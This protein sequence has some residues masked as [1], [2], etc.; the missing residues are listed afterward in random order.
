MVV[1]PSGL[2]QSMIG[3]SLKHL[4]EFNA[5]ALTDIGPVAATAK[6]ASGVKARSRQDGK[7]MTRRPFRQ[8]RNRFLDLGQWRI[9]VLLGSMGSTTVTNSLLKTL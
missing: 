3:P 8:E 9:L 4:A 2:A 7:R 5:W 1:V 6:M